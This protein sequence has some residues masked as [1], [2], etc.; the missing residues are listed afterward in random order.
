[1][2]ESI[3]HESDAVNAV[4]GRFLEGSSGGQPWVVVRSRPLQSLSTG[5]AQVEVK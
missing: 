4:P 2:D 3:K 1:M 5:I